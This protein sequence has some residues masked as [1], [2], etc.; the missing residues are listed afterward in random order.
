MSTLEVSTVVC[1]SPQCGRKTAGDSTR[2]WLVS[3]AIDLCPEHAN[4]TICPPSHR[5]DET[6]TCYTRHGCRC[7][8]CRIR[9]A[10]YTLDRARGAMTPRPR[11]VKPEVTPTPAG[12]QLTLAPRD[13]RMVAEA[14]EERA[15]RIHR[16]ASTSGVQAPVLRATAA[17]I[18]DLAQRVAAAGTRQETR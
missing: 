13:A 15:V 10:Q 3:E 18:H 6:G 12:V 14:L 9:R 4:V 1:D 16:A 5:H 7:G 11:P 17:R 8:P 2:G